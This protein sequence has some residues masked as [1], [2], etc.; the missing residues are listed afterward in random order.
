MKQSRV[1]VISNYGEF[2]PI[3]QRMAAEGTD[4]VCYIHEPDY[5]RRLDGIV[6]KVDLAGL[7]PRLR[8]CDTVIFDITQHNRK[9]PHDLQLLSKFGLRASEKDLFGSIADRLKRPPYDVQ[10]I[11]ASRQASELEWDREKGIELARKIGLD[12]PRYEVFKTVRDG[13]RFLESSEGSNRRWVLK[14]WDDAETEWTYCEKFEGELVDILRNNITR[15]FGDRFEFMLQEF[16]D[17]VEYATEQWQDLDNL[18]R[19]YTRT[20]ECK[21]L[22]DGNMGK[23]TGSQLN[24]YWIPEQIDKRMLS[25]FQKAN[26]ILADSYIGMWDINCIYQGDKRYFLEHTR[27]F[28]W[29]S[30]AL[31]CSLVPTG[32][33]ST[34]MLHGFAA[35]M[36]PAIVS[37]QVVSLWP[38]PGG[39]KNELGENIKGNLINHKL[40]QLKDLWLQD[41]YLGADGCLRVGGS[42][43]FVGVQ[44]G[45]GNDAEASIDSLFKKLD[46][47][48]I[49]GNTQWR[50]KQDHLEQINKRIK[51]LKSWGVEL[52]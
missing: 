47:L 49:T 15:K 44:V 13:I 34:F 1:L 21:K 39:S 27:R 23:A 24:T 51:K 48:E 3:A 10:V 28:G 19:F 41:A 45:H 14:P 36:K 40:D 8:K 22:A 30:T 31:C 7:L 37:S 26:K 46:R 32:A 11:G 6:P 16:I 9:K 18:P 35:E 25:A 17:G 5:K 42:D 20:L 52:W 43:G 50:T 29:S 2:T 33:L 4:V 38:Y 12:I